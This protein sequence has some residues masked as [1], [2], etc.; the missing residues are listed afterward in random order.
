MADELAGAADLVKGK[1]SGCPAAVVRG[2][3][4]LVLAPGRHGPGAAALLRPE[5]EDMFGLGSREAVV[6]AV[7]G[8]RDD[9]RGF[10][11][12]SSGEELAVALGRMLDGCAARVRADE[13]GLE[14]V[15]EGLTPRQA[16]ATQARVTA[17]AHGH[18]RGVAHRRE[19]RETDVRVRLVPG[20]P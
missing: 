7:T 2:L 5:S 13:L 18:G 3:G 4:H 12:P 9:R 8:D 15:V 16:G 14:V 11:A 20:T 19:D 6:A 10:G 17:V 1:L